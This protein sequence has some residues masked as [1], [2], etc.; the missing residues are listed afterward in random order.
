ML[1]Y[2]QLLREVPEMT[3]ATHIGLDKV[4]Q[5][6]AVRGISRTTAEKCNLLVV[7][8]QQLI[9]AARKTKKGNAEDSRAAIVFPHFDPTGQP[10]DWWSARLVELAPPELK[11]VTEGISFA[12][13]VEKKPLGKMFCPPVEAPHAYLPPLLDWINIPKGSK[14][15]IHE[16]CIKSINGAL[17]G[18]Y[19]VGLNGV[20]G[21]TSKKH[22]IGLV[23][24]LRS[25]PWKALQLEPVILFDSNINDNWDVQQAA[26]RLAAKIY[27]YTGREAR[28]LRLPKADGMVDQGFDDFCDQHTPAEIKEFLEKPTEEIAISEIEL[29]K[30]QLN[31]EVCVVR[32]ISRVVN[33][34][35]GTV[36]KRSDFT[37]MNYAHFQVLEVDDKGRPHQVNVPKLWL[38]D[39]KR[40]EVEALEYAPGERI[41]FNDKLNMWRG[42]GCEP[43]PGDPMPWIN[44]LNANVEDEFVR[45]WITCWLAYPL[46]NLGAKMNSYLLLFGPSGTGKDLFL[47]PMQRIYG[48]NFVKIGNEEIRSQFSSLYA[49]RQF[50]QIDELARQFDDGPSVGQKIKRLT[51]DLKITVNEKNQPEFKVDNHLNMAI[52]S[53]YP[54]C[55]KLDD[56]DRRAA[57]VNWRAWEEREDHRGDEAYWQNYINW[58]DNG[59]AEALYDYLLQYPLGKF[60]PMAWAPGTEAKQVVKEA[61]KSMVERWVADLDAD[62]DSVLPIISAGK[63]LW[64]SKDLAIV[65]YGGN[66][67]FLKK[68]Q[69]D[70]IGVALRDAGFKRANDGKVIRDKNGKVDRYWVIRDRKDKR[71]ADSAACSVSISAQL[72]TGQGKV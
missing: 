45:D 64:T 59:G 35:T 33:Q 14:V 2:A 66:E 1:T 47:R 25:L 56:D 31:N 61:T 16:S 24:E 26:S 62:P 44:L 65:F 69:I 18:T 5:Y 58:C 43:E 63:A 13:L 19:S 3:D 10:I 54:D 72:G 6:L 21:W 34:H 11:L 70:Q 7:K 36:M 53:N 60:N 67:D 27:E 57:V 42:M 9:A 4:W 46:Q 38:G 50:V 8:A 71:W 41:I 55:L 51:T 15:Y 28:L 17:A 22:N 12:S 52:T 23:E 39:K 30:I 37:D 68:S 49:M 40:V 29:L 48:P 20:W 32:S